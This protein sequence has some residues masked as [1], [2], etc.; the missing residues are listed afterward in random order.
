MAEIKKKAE[1]EGQN[2]EEMAEVKT[3]QKEKRN[4]QFSIH[5]FQAKFNII[6]GRKINSLN[7]RLPIQKDYNRYKVLF[8]I[9]FFITP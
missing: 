5:Q 8:L 4:L 9:N 3:L 7:D 6:H 1:D 2:I